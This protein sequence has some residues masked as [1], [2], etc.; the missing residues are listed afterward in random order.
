MDYTTWFEYIL[1]LLLDYSYSLL[2]GLLFFTFKQNLDYLKTTLIQN[3]TKKTRKIDINI[4]YDMDLM[5]M[6]IMWVTIIVINIMG[7]NI[8]KRKRLII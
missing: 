1:Q 2:N 4:F 8:N 6:L 3:L 7:I 5:L